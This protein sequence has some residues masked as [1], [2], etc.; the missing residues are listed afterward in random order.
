VKISKEVRRRDAIDG[1]EE[2][3]DIKGIGQYTAD[4]VLCYG[5]GYHAVPIDVNVARVG[6]HYFEMELPSDLRYASD[7]R[8]RMEEV[9]TVEDPMTLNWALQDLGNALRSN[10][11]PLGI[12]T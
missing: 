11:D 6:E 10:S 5:F 3:I 7:L 1:R 4:A 9:V 8:A 2:L 12:K